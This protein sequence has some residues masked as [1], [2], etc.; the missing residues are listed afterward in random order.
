MRNGARQRRS[1]QGM[2]TPPTLQQPCFVFGAWLLSCSTYGKLI[3]LHTP[4]EM[5]PF[6]EGCLA[7]L[8]DLCGQR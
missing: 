5:Q 2:L 7:L 3:V 6:V 1:H 8:Q 4:D